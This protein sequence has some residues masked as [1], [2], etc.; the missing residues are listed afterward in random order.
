M[1]RPIAGYFKGDGLALGRTT[2]ENC[3]ISSWGN[4]TDP[5]VQCPPNSISRPGDNAD[6]SK[7]A[8]EHGYVKVT[9]PGEDFNFV[10]VPN[11]QVTDVSLPS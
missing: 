6:L 3:S 4:D 1:T 11:F 5:C 2:F 10:C 9:D 7:C 8:C